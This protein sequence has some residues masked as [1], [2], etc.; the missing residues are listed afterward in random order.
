MVQ[1]VC[2]RATDIFL[3]NQNVHI[4]LCFMQFIQRSNVSNTEKIWLQWWIQEFKNRGGGRFQR[5]IIF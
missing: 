1:L 5:G 4:F 2:V 3:L